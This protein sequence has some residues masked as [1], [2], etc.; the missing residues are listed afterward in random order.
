MYLVLP[1]DIR[2]WVYTSSTNFMRCNAQIIH[3]NMFF[4]WI[5]WMNAKTIN[6]FNQRHGE[7][8]Q[9]WYSQYQLRSDDC[10]TGTV[11][12][13][14]LESILALDSSMWVILTQSGR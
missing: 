3:T 7:S 13:L 11:V 4:L 9:W 6:R 5:E 1:A 2:V 10:E 12:F 8:V 14:Y